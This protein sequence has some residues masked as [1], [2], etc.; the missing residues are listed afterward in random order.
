M[1]A[2]SPCPERWTKNSCETCS[3]HTTQK[4]YRSWLDEHLCICWQPP[5]SI[6]GWYHLAFHFKDRWFFDFHS[7]NPFKKIEITSR[8]WETHCILP[9][10]TVIKMCLH[11]NKTRCGENSHTLGKAYGG[12]RWDSQRPYADGKVQKVWATVWCPWGRMSPWRGMDPS[13]L[14]GI[15]LE[16]LKSIVGTEGQ[17]LLIFKLSTKC[18]LIQCKYS[19]NQRSLPVV[20]LNYENINCTSNLSLCQWYNQWYLHAMQR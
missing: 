18:S 19:L 17:D 14:Q 12:E 6:L 10:W 16:S 1:T 4:S 20:N 13:V 8:I 3:E 11:C 15:W 9:K 5:R 2:K 7:I